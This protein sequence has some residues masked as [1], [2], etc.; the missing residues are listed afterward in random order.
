[1]VEIS[2]CGDWKKVNIEDRSR[3]TL[4]PFYEENYQTRRAHFLRNVPEI[5]TLSF[6]FWPIFMIF[7]FFRH[8]IHLLFELLYLSCV[9]CDFIV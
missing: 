8:P 7:Q 1:M 3:L 4:T 2:H 6:F 9:I 5:L